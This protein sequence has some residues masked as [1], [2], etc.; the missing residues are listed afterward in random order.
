MLGRPGGGLGEGIR[1]VRFLALCSD[2]KRA[3][4]YNIRAAEGLYRRQ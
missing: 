1:T 2:I 4:V 3:S